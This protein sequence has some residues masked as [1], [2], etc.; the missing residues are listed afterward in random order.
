ME[1][2]AEDIRRL[3]SSAYDALIGALA[4]EARREAD[5]LVAAPDGQ[6]QRQQGRARLAAEL[7][8]RVMGASD[9]LA[10]VDT[11]HRIQQNRAKQRDK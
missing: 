9:K 4:Y 8:D 7:L 10:A 1:Q 3:S 5:F 2:A 6:L 11:Q